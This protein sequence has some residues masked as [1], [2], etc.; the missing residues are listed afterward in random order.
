MSLGLSST[1]YIRNRPF[2]NNSNIKE[3]RIIGDFSVYSVLCLC[4]CMSMLLC[5]SHAWSCY[6]GN[7][8]LEMWH[9]HASSDY[10]KGVFSTFF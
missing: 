4:V 2:Y 1:Q 9:G 3:K 7:K 10:L 8:N 6:H 5:F